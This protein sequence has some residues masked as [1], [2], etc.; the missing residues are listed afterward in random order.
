MNALKKAA[1][2]AKGKVCEFFRISHC[3]PHLHSNTPTPLIIM[4]PETDKQ[5][6]TLYLPVSDDEDDD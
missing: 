5:T 4:Q 1:T 6:T 3:L 2:D